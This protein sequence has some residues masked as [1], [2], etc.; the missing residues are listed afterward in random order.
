MT[1]QLTRRRFAR[2]MAAAGALA[3]FPTP[4]LWA[5]GAATKMKIGI[6]P[7]ISSG[8]IFIAEAR[9]YFEKI[10]LD[11]DI[12]YFKDGALAMP[13]LVAGELDATATTLNA[14]LF[15][16]IAKGAPYKLVLDRGIEKPGSGSM[17][18]AA[19]NAMVEA[20]MTAPAKM[21]LLK[22]KKIAIQAPGSIDQYLFGRGLQ[23]LG[24]D[25]RSDVEWSSGLGYPDMV[26]A[27]GAGQVD[28]ANIPVPLGFLV[29]K[30]KFGK[31]V[32][33]GWD[34]E[35]NC[36]LACWAMSTNF[37]AKNKEAAVLF[38]MAHIHAGRVFNQAAASKDAT[39]VKI[40]ADA[41]KVPPALIE[42]AAP[43]WTW[44]A[45]DGMPNVES[46]LAQGKFWTETMKL[47][48]ASVT[49]DQLFELSPAVEATA[50]LKKGNPFG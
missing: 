11:V 40:V 20:G 44:Y 33:S 4:Y 8:P 24:H 7:L 49:K 35:P 3:A 14:G 5:Q 34:I 19:S 41:T 23:K 25:P 1:E 13:A 43:R 26:K 27:M 45:D 46:C 42:L 38:A 17:T 15:N 37:M 47:V 22:G 31:L 18:I 21:A 28:A 6:V 2:A 16:T 29:E 36:Q 30:N 12:Q 9:K 10:R 39:V 48:N 50:R 32:F